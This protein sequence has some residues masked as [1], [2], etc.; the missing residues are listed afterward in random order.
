MRAALSSPSFSAR[1]AVAVAI[2][3]MMGFG[4]LTLAL[5]ALETGAAGLVLG[6]LLALLPMP[7]YMG[8]ALWVDRYE[9]EPLAM[10][11]LS[12]LW[13]GTVAV[14]ASYLLNSLVGALFLAAGGRSAAEV[15]TAIISAPVVEESAKAVALFALFFL[16]RDEFD[17]V[18]DGVVYAAMVGLGFATA[19]NVLYYGK[20]ATEGVGSSMA[21]FLMRGV[22]SPYSHPLFTAMVGIGLGI[23]RET[24]DSGV[25]WAAP[26][27]GVAL[28]IALHALWNLSASLGWPFF[29]AYLFI[30]LP[31]FL[32]VIALLSW[33]MGRE[34]AIL[35][36]QL[37]P[38]LAGGVLSPDEVERVASPGA[39]LM[40]RM[41]ALREEG[42]VGWR[43]AGA[44]HRAAV[45]LAFHG[46]RRGRGLG[47]GH[48]ADKAREREVVERMR[49]LR[50][51]AANR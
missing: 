8:L 15:G 19:E 6:L 35:R 31:S 50:G 28:A 7:V 40:E 43:R 29:V 16:K 13:G 26:I 9:R 48:E 4:L 11:V 12:F 36:A 21:A 42:P 20:A 32:G 10:L 25:R 39:R 41:E 1:A 44:F 23:A 2:L 46:W 18:T 24:R 49:S 47:R 17:N 38:Y 34:R 27:G 14:F 30:M 45:E 51:P 3:T 5:V 37:A 33:S 22:I